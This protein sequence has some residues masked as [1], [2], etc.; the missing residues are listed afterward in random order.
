MLKKLPS[1]IERFEA[2]V[3]KQPNGCWLWRGADANG[4]GAFRF[5]GTVWRAHRAAL[6]LYRGTDLRSPSEKVDRVDDILICHSC[7]TRNCV[8]PDHLILGDAAFN[9]RDM[10]A[11]GRGSNGRRYR[12]LEN[13]NGKLS[14]AQVQ[15]IRDRFASGTRQVDLA[16]QFGVSRAHIWKLVRNRAREAP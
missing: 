11:K 14:D 16:H 2:K 8:N 12:G 13:H 15:E 3:E 6:V 4:Y 1:D 7:D 10:A 9:M 5:Q